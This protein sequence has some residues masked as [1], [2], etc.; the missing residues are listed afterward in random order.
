MMWRIHQEGDT[1]LHR[2]NPTIKLIAFSV[3]ILVPTLFL[4]PV[5]PAVFLAASLVLAWGLG[6]LSPL[7]MGR[8]LA[9]FLLVGLGLF[10]FNTLFYGGAK[11]HLLFALGPLRIWAEALSLGAS[12]GLRIICI[13]SFSMT[14]V[15]TTDPTKF[16][17][18][19]AQQ[20]R[21]P[22][23][24]SY[25]VLVAYRFIPILQRELANIRDAHAVR[26]AYLERRLS[27]LWE[28]FRRYG[29]PLLASGVRQADRLAIAMD[30]RGFGALPT[31]TFYVNTVV[32]ARDY[33]FLAGA[34]LLCLAILFIL[35]RLGLLKGF[36]AGVAETI[37]NVQVR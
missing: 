20:G 37:A 22:Y 5:T 33:L 4:D 8:R 3:L 26:G 35:A 18:S 1:F 27:T 28:R 29:I 25:T 36:L 30:A 12:V 32:K 2:L 24:L 9:P 15:L 14:F 13:A 17:A 23:R 31:H 10:F 6:G 21:L 16:A 7:T 11:E 19:L 34:L